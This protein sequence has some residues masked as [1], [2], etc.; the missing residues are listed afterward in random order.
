MTR[1]RKKSEI[2]RIYAKIGIFIAILAAGFAIISCILGMADRQSLKNTVQK[3]ENNK[4][5]YQGTA[6]VPRGNLETYLFAGIDDPGKVEQI[7]EYD[8]SGQC[9]VLILLVRDRSTDQCQLVTIDRNTITPVQSLEDDGNYISTDDMQISL[10]HAMS[11]DHITRAE[12][13]VQ[14]VSTLLNG[15]R[16]DYYAMVNM[17]AIQTVNDLVGGVT[18]TIQDDFTGVDDSLKK[19]ET[20][21]LTG[22]QAEHFIRGRMTMKDDDTNQNRMARQ[23]QYEDGFKTAFRQKCKED[24]TFPLQMYHVLEDYMT[25]NIN[26][27]KFSRLSLLLTDG[28][29]VGRLSI[30]GKYGVDDSDWQT[31]VPDENSL[32]QVIL[33]LFYE[34]QK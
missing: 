20:V 32:E 21:T 30:D 24:N 23:T 7:S 26:A 18:V 1:Y 5:L 9:D 27:K 2:K 8:G 34:K 4:I 19:G 17:G 29:E 16:I 31:F 11:L 10:A 15:A 25:T 33:T 6:Y 3:N 14:A 12:N 13:T 22:S 28:R